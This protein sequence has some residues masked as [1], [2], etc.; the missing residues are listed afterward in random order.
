NSTVGDT[1]RIQ[2]R[3]SAPP[4]NILDS[5]KSK[6]NLTGN[7]D[8]RFYNIQRNAQFYIVTKHRNYLETWSHSPK[9]FTDSSLTFDFTDSLTK[10]YG[11]NLTLIDNFPKKFALYGGDINHDDYI[12]L[13]DL[14]LIYNDITNFMSGYLPTDL[15]GDNG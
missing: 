6:F 12:D 9:K 3:K 7:A 15:T 8:F 14:I 13:S 5:S 4:Y 10:A 2:L 11:S 1:L